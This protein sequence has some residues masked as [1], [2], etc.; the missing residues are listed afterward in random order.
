MYIDIYIC[1]YILYYCQRPINMLLFLSY[2]RAG[3]KIAL[4][5]KIPDAK[6]KFC[7]HKYL[8]DTPIS[9]IRCLKSL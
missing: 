3:R 7:F 9:I 2:P 6:I 5:S 1:I 8:I 4:R